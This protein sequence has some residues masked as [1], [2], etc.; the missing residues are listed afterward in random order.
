MARQGAGVCSVSL[1]A[2]VA[3]CDSTTVTER[4]PPDNCFVVSPSRIIVIVICSVLTHRLGLW[5][6]SILRFFFPVIC[7]QSM[8]RLL[9]LAL[10]LTSETCGTALLTTPLKV[11]EARVPRSDR[12]PC[13]LPCQFRHHAV[14]GKRFR[15]ALLPSVHSSEPGVGT[16]SYHASD[17]LWSLLQSR[18]WLRRHVEQ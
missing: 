18:R 8:E 15:R 7:D 17:F 4:V 1:A 11:A 2:C 3:C 10:V 6:V 9:N 16:R 13:H 14:S 12:I 5:L